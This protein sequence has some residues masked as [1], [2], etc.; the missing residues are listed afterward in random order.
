MWNWADIRKRLSRAYNIKPAQWT[1]PSWKP[2]QIQQ[3]LDSMRQY[4]ENDVEGAIHWYYAKKPWKAWASQLL[5]FLTLFATGLG[6]LLPIVSATGIFSPANASDAQRQLR[7]LQV[8]QIGYLCFGL[9]AAF[10]AF[11]KYFGYSTGW[12]RYITTAMSLETALRNFRLDW[13]LT[14]SSLAGAVPSGA[15]LETLLQKIQD[16]CIAARTLVEKETQAWVMEFQTNLSQLEKEAKAAMDSAR[17]AVE[18]A[19]KESKAAA[20]STRPGA[21]D[22]TVENVL[23]TDHG[24][25]VSVDGELRKSAVTGK[26]CAIMNVAPGLHELAVTALMSGLPAHASRIVTVAAGTAEKVRIA[27]DQAKVTPAP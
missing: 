27:L 15:T 16:F 5:K 9:A 25:D 23:D 18:T 12:M 6:G 8:N 24:Y 10:L 21:I 19:Q 20:D 4:A 26:T 3:C 2:D 11:D 22:L 7:T 17:A 13:A 1:P 14:T